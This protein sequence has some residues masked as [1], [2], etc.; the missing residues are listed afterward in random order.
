M[1]S[2]LVLFFALISASSYASELSARHQ[3]LI[4][5]AV[6][7]KCDLRASLKLESVKVVEDRIDQGVIDYYFTSKFTAT[8]HIDQGVFDYYDV[9]VKSAEYSGYDHEA[10]DWG[11]LE[12]QSVKCEMI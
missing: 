4:K 9:T 10:Q 11:M 5:K 7:E 6:E 1:K 3:Q 8:V 12:I 2:F